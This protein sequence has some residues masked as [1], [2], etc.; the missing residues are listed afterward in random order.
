[1]KKRLLYPYRITG[2]GAEKL[3]NTLRG[4]GF[5][6]YGIAWENVRRVSF[7]V[8]PDQCGRLEE[9]LQR[10]GFEYEKKPPEGVMKKLRYLHGRKAAVAACAVFVALALFSL[11]LVWKIDIDGA[12]SYRG[13]IN[14]WLRENGIAPFTRKSRIDLQDMCESLLYRL[15]EITWVR[16]KIRGVIL[17]I[18]ITRSVV[19]EEDAFDTRPGNVIASSDGIVQSVRVFQGTAAVR[20]G[21]TVK[22]GQ[23]LIYGY[24]N[25]EDGRRE[26]VRA[27]GEIRVRTWK[28]ADA[29][30]YAG[31][32]VSV[33]TGRE[34]VVKAF[35]CPWGAV[36]SGSEPEYLACDKQTETFP[37]GGAWIPVWMEK[38]IYKETALEK[39]EA[40]WESAKSEAGRLAMRKLL[41]LCDKNDEIIDKWL[42]CCMIEGD[43][44]QATATAEL[45]AETGAFS[46]QIPD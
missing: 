45:I 46:P 26:A 27:K 38:T 7:S 35:L 12:G 24:E 16:A 20:P 34:T 33:P 14:A 32:T 2:A 6:L 11:R 9:S 29:L 17:D 3:L 25:R 36:R 23:T 19:A 18:D 41:S 15:P 21:D 43:T 39:E 22:K 44:I 8:S 5:A 13:E 10:L 1:M 42:N 30:V 4:E 37:I 28:S 31:K 40:D